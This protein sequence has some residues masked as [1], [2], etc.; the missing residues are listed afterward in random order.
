MGII[1]SPTLFG[2]HFKKEIGKMETV[3]FLVSLA[4]HEIELKLTDAQ[5]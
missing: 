2:G 4:R 1:S 3:E 5:T